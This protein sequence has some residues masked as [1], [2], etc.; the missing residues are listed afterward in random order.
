MGVS[1]MY[2]KFYESA[3]T[4]S[5]FGAGL[6]VFA[7]W[8]Y[9]I[10][11]VGPDH[12]VEINPK[13]VASVLGCKPADVERALEYLMQPDPESR[14]NKEGGRR[15][16]K[17]GSFLYRVVNHEDYSKI[18]TNAERR[19]YMR[20]KQA[21]SRARKKAAEVKGG[22]S[23]T[24]KRSTHVD[25][26]VDVDTS[27]KTSSSS[28][29]RKDDDAFVAKVL[30]FW[31]REDLRPKARGVSDQRRSAILARARQHNKELVMEVLENRANSRFLCYEFNSGRGAPIDWVFGPQNFVK[32]M[33]GNY[34]D[35]LG[36]KKLSPEDPGYYEDP[37]WVVDTYRREQRRL[38]R[39]G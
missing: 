38:S 20:I 35:S 25:V 8:G 12:H 36:K 15:L 2:G 28:S 29:S 37:E 26:D 1:D 34:N 30:T 27:K 22:Q 3:F 14:S 9:I 39:S 5:M 10:A 31:A 13:L 21:E 7:V 19:E 24:S 32:V 23:K 18:R 17:E 11:T 4:G 16:T 33:D 6:H